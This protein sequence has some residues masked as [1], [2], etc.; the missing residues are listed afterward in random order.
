MTSRK[1]G[2]TMPAASVSELAALLTTLDEFLRSGPPVGD[3]L[4]G[5]LASRGA[6]FPGFDA[7]NLTDDLSFTALRFRRLA[8]ETSDTSR[9]QEK[10]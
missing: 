3:A 9:H 5:F 10:P 6:R 4:A 7:C 2:I 8:P 1:T